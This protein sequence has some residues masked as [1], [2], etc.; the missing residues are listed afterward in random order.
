MENID[1][2]TIRNLQRLTGRLRRD[3]PYPRIFFIAEESKTVLTS[4]D[5]LEAAVEYREKRGWDLWG[6][7]PGHLF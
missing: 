2:E 4:L 3:D 7:H 1:R 6:C 5:V